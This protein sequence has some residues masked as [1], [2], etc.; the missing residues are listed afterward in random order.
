[1]G[2][3]RTREWDPKHLEM[4]WTDFCSVLALRKKKKKKKITACGMVRYWT[5]RQLFNTVRDV[6]IFY[7]LSKTG[8]ENKTLYMPL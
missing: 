1:M 7:T 4:T 2:M 6:Q 8:N 5:T 3:S